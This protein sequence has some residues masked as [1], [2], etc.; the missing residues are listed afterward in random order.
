MS[1]RVTSADDDTA[2]LD[3]QEVARRVHAETFAAFGEG[4]E[5]SYDF[6]TTHERV[7]RALGE[8]R[9][10]T[11]PEAIQPWEC[12]IGGSRFY[13]PPINISVSSVFKSGNLTGA[14]IRQQSAPKF[15]SG[16]TE[17]VISMTL[18]FASYEEIFGFE[19]EIFRIQ[20][21]S[22]DVD[23]SNYHPAD[24]HL[25]NM[26]PQ[27]GSDDETID[28]FL[29]SLRGLVAQFKY[30][31]FLP[32]RNDYLNRAFGITG[33]VLK[34]MSIS[35]I[36]SYPFCMAV[37]LTM[38]KF[39]HKVYLPMIEHFDQAIHW[40]RFRQ[41]MG[42]AAGRLAQSSRP[43]KEF[44]MATNSISGSETGEII[45]TI[46][47][48]QEI[49]DDVHIE[50]IPSTQTYRRHGA[51]EANRFDF[52][53]P[54][55]T[56]ARV[57]LPDL[58]D[59][60][61]DD[62]HWNQQRKN[63]WQRFLGV[64]GFDVNTNREEYVAA[65][66][67]AED[68]NTGFIVNQN[69][70]KTLRDYL[71]R[72]S[73]A[74]EMMS[75]AELNTYFD[76]RLEE[77]GIQRGTAA[78]SELRRQ[79]DSTW[80]YAMY[81][82]FMEDPSLSRALANHD[83]RGKQL[84]INE[85]EI[86]M[87]KRNL[88]P[89]TVKIEGVS[90]TLG[91]VIARLQLQM[92]DEPT[93]QHIGGADT[94]IDIFMT[95]S[96]EHA[97]TELVKLRTMFDHVSGLA[98]LE[99]G[100]GVLGFLGVQNIMTELIGTRYVVP[101]SFQ[102]DTVP[103][104]PH[105][106]KVQIS[107]TDF[108]IFQQKRESLGAEQQAEL[109]A[110]FGKRN[111]FFRIKQLWGMFNAYPDF[112]LSVRDDEGKVVGHLDPDF[113]F[114]S[115]KSLDD[116]I[117]L[118]EES[119]RLS[120]IAEGSDS[121]KIRAAIEE[122][123]REQAADAQRKT[124]P[125]YNFLEGPG[126]H[127]CMGMGEHGT[128]E[129]CSI[130]DNGFSLFSGNQAA[131]V[132][133]HLNEPHAGNMLTEPSN[134]E[135][136]DD[137]SDFTPPSGYMQPYL[138][139]S[140]DPWFQFDAMSQDMLYRDKGGRMIR[141]YPTYMLWLIDESTV[142]G[143]KMFDNFY[144][145]QSVIDMSLVQ[146]KEILGD[147]L[148][149]RV[150]NL[151][152][153]LSTKMHD[154]LDENDTGARII[155]EFTRGMHRNLSNSG[156]IVDLENI[157]L[158]PGVRLHLRMG[159]G[160]NPNNLDTV[161][162]G[163]VTEV[164][165]GEVLTIIAQ[166]DAIELGAMVN[167]TNEKGHTGKIDGGM[168]GLYMSE[169]RDLMITLLTQGST[170]VRQTIAHATQGEVFSENRY[171]IR[172]FGSMFYEPLDGEER[173]KVGRN[174]HRLSSIIAR[175]SEDP[176]ST[177]EV[178]GMRSMA[179][180]DVMNA[181]WTNLAAKRDY[182]VFKRNIYPGNGTG[183]AQ[184]VG[185]DLGEYGLSTAIDNTASMRPGNGIDDPAMQ[186]NIAG[187]G[188]AAIDSAVQLQQA[189][190]PET[191][192]SMSI[193]R[194]ITATMAG[195]LSADL[196]KGVIAGSVTER[197]HSQELPYANTSSA[198]GGGKTHNMLRQMGVMKRQEDEDGPFDEVTFR[199]QT[200][201]K[202]VWDLFQVCAAL[203]PD[204]IVAVRPF[205]DR[206][207]IFYGKPHWLYT[208]GL[209]PLT[210]GLPEAE[211]PRIEAPDEEFLKIW[212]RIE[213]TLAEQNNLESFEEF[214]SGIDSWH[215][216]NDPNT[217]TSDLTW[218]GEASGANLAARAAMQA[219]FEGE[220][221]VTMVA[222]AGAESN[223]RPE[224]NNAGMNRDGTTDYGMWQVNRGAHGSWVDFSRITDPF[225][226]AEVAFELVS[227]KK[228]AGN[229]RIFGD[230]AVHDH[231][232]IANPARGKYEQYM[233]RARRAV[234][235]ERSAARSSNDL[236]RGEQASADR[237]TAQAEAYDASTNN[238]REYDEGYRDDGLAVSADGDEQIA[239]RIYGHNRDEDEAE[240]IWEEV[241]QFFATDSET[242]R[243]FLRAKQ[244]QDLSE[245]QR[246]EVK[247]Q[248]YDDV[249]EGFINFMYENPYSRAWVVKT[250]SKRVG[251]FVL[252]NLDRA[253]GFVLDIGRALG[254][255]DD[256]EPSAT[257]QAQRIW[258][259]GPLYE[260]FA[261]YI[262]Y[263]DQAAI[264]YMKNNHGDGRNQS[265]L[266]ARIFETTAAGLLKAWDGFNDLRKRAL[267]AVGG[268]ATGLI[269]FMRLQ[270]M[271]LSSG[272][273]MA[274]NMQRQTNALNRIF[275]DSI[276]YSAGRDSEGR[277]VNPMLYYADNPFT[278]EYAEPV[279]EVREPFQRMHTLGSFQNILNNS[280][281][282]TIDDVA[283]VVTAT[284]NGQHPVT[285]HFDKAAPSEKQVEKIVDTGL[286]YDHPK[287]WFGLKKVLSPIET[288]RW[289]NQT[290]GSSGDG[291]NMETT[292]KRVALKHLKDNLQNIYQGEL[293]ILGDSSIRPHDLVYMGDVYERMYGFFEVQQ[294][295]HHLTP[296]TGFVTSVTPNACVSIN[297]P[298]RFMM[299][300]QSKKRADTASL[301]QH[302]RQQFKVYAD[303]QGVQSIGSE[304]PSMTEYS[305]DEVVDQAE[306]Q[307][308]NS[309]QF[310]GGNTAVIKSIAG[311]AG[312]G[313]VTQSAGR[314]IV[315]AGLVSPV[316]GVLSWY[317]W[318][319][320]RDNLLDQQG[321]WI[322]YLTHNG[323]PMDAGLSYN[324]SV[325][326]GHQHT[327]SL[328]IKGLKLGEI[329][330][331]G[332]DGNPT[333]RTQDV[334]PA[335]RWDETGPS[336][337]AQAVS[338]FVDRT[339]AEVRRLAG[340]E[341]LPGGFDVE[342]YWI[343]ITR[344]T[345]ADTFYFNVLGQQRYGEFASSNAVL[346]NGKL[347]PAG[348]D[349]PE[350]EF[351][352]RTEGER[353][354]IYANDPGVRATEFARSLLM[355]GGIGIEVAVR[356]DRANR[357]D[358]FGRTLGYIFHRAPEGMEG[359]ERRDFIL[360]AATRIPPVSYDS[361]MPDGQPYTFD[362]EMIAAGHGKVFTNDMKRDQVGR[363]VSGTQQSNIDTPWSQ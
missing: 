58:S 38:Y 174:K 244:M 359:E 235:E 61:Y 75:R 118:S 287:G 152:S 353:A 137:F 141:A 113:Y 223:W 363:G 148:V 22:G 72:V 15:N 97:E 27:A 139:N 336:A 98:R 280:I 207:T 138:D 275:N 348:V 230:W 14:A 8:E 337:Q 183:V 159:Y 210:T 291:T 362:W 208:S 64:M 48:A 175:V 243:K 135:T 286:F 197:H 52:Y 198:V 195:M 76:R 3:E 295:V 56:P 312:A 324:S 302:M 78:A 167:S 45:P 80:F 335:L 285:V 79:V 140:G 236:S 355:P 161:F 168:V 361:Y 94:Q 278:R 33:V 258:E 213:T 240:Q 162:N 109:V 253:R 218:S 333:I 191:E 316:A 276:Y 246:R 134:E 136:D 354:T 260:A 190:D 9:D 19:D 296:E 57:E 12:R 322:Q 344:V 177:G 205:E 67:M 303:D 273:S 269:Q 279:V 127:Y 320:V 37:T 249:V 53:Y 87:V 310:T 238:T 342:A 2:T 277:V 82:F 146:S 30:A 100:H 315:G 41:Y 267:S 271:Q 101:L 212:E 120:N 184:F 55:S 172:H 42:R 239:E 360:S 128:A 200:Y 339:N 331:L 203:L 173:D 254:F 179:M 357:Q 178:L 216:S 181:A 29:S 119:Q 229:S 121:D 301:R 186:F 358:Q 43:I 96:G 318:K 349:A 39:N 151:Y 40:G 284:S 233:E 150:S 155:N 143:M 176:D 268:I 108:D 18:Y 251:G 158:Q 26:A 132:N 250:T 215:P 169:P 28:K 265:K 68:T 60:R 329:P 326:V 328:V 241:R 16:H 47:S 264:E 300:A 242:E 83:R 124:D 90:V 222:I 20:F 36:P 307:I 314:G 46:R 232:A 346:G 204:Y 257:D 313:G 234:D 31:P 199:A 23:V 259:F 7:Y 228:R 133:A 201:M 187:G 245:S 106:Y 294:V 142:A 288:Q 164:H 86:P 226:N 6:N 107:L 147:T 171:G 219:G 123:T 340:R 182:E 263:G 209:I 319:W 274:S 297:D 156:W 224:I 89:D 50:D 261:Q 4:F 117:F 149:L 248:V 32:I 111:P 311:M 77:E 325:A 189:P 227:R 270:M 103:N 154:Y 92:Q 352:N 13:I 170:T 299:I 220:E 99:H 196:A 71:L 321:A 309:L 334:L 193:E 292:A 262:S 308:Q 66:K 69:E 188:Q 54:L 202:T 65:R 21:D 347:R 217:S 163:V 206:S 129:Y 338:L 35:T 112:P 153:K 10:N 252:R 81:K 293:T 91:N 70:Y 255:G 231:Y 341:T 95:I 85:W 130:D 59:L 105:V 332:R 165:T 34:D 102:V 317:G 74:R 114:R 298:A 166:S 131:V 125:S 160:A 343:R 221:L 63:W 17:T 185:G 5:S 289:I 49:L 281:I 237:Y 93:H 306:T 351:K 272:M 145:L 214:F 44:N 122:V 350:D 51:F 84:T 192:I 73:L 225:Y 290:S 345:D 356:I 62:V 323:R 266:I 110:A 283:T 194:A 144:G 330:T 305:M 247:D 115:F 327:K 282:E 126:I 304:M 88:D 211:A 1:N 25:L 157:Q 104:N 24:R 116:D 180:F 256:E 11:P